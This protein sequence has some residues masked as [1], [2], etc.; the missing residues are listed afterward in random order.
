MKYSGLIGNENCEI[1]EEDVNL[2]ACYV[3]LP[4][5]CKI[6]FNSKKFMGLQ[7]SPDPCKGNEIWF[8]KTSIYLK[9]IVVLEYDI[10]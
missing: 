10:N 4:T 6:T 2:P 8:S 3:I 1:K 7:M 5:N 9:A